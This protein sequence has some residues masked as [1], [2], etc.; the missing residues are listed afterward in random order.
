M[1]CGV[2]AGADGSSLSIAYKFEGW[3]KTQE[4]TGRCYSSAKITV[5]FRL[6]SVGGRQALDPKLPSYAWST[7]T[8]LV[9]WPLECLNC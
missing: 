7:Q 9:W 1:G 2:G 8:H 6:N 4:S 5:T 3:Q